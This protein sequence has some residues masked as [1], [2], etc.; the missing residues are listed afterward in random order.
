MRGPLVNWKSAAAAAMLLLMAA[1]ESALATGKPSTRM[2]P[3]T[4]RVLFVERG[5]R[6]NP[7]EFQR[8]VPVHDLRT[9]G[10]PKFVNAIEW[11]KFGLPC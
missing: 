10:S 3:Y 2:H 4:D 1:P 6:A 7:R 9:R 11:R 5:P 8:I